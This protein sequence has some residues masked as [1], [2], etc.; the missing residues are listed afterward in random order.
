M[1]NNGERSGIH[2]RKASGGSGGG[3]A[4]PTQLK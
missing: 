3:G 4:A 2:S 1:S